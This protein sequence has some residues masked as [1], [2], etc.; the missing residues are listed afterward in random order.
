[1]GGLA[2]AR[3]WTA[4]MSWGQVGNSRRS[5]RV[6]NKTPHDVAQVA[7]QRETQFSPACCFFAAWRLLDLC[8]REA[9]GSEATH[10]QAY[11]GRRLSDAVTLNGSGRGLLPPPSSAQCLTTHSGDEVSDALWRLGS[12][13]VSGKTAEEVTAWPE[14]PRYIPWLETATTPMPVSGSS[15]DADCS[16]GWIASKGTKQYQKQ[17]VEGAPS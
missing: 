17:P 5:L 11:R 12:D 4:I 8:Q 13:I 14:A 10:W 6:S 2:L 7:S 16:P 1:M 9:D 15:G 3:F